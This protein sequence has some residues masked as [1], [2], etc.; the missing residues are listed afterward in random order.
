[1]NN[2]INWLE[3]TN[4][5]QLN[6][7][8]QQWEHLN[9]V[10]NDFQ[11]F[12]SP[13][14]IFSW[15]ETYWKNNWHLSVLTAWHGQQLIAIVPLYYQKETVF[16]L[17]TLYPLGQGE[18]E[19]K[20]VSSEYLDI[21]IHPEYQS[22]TSSYITHWINKRHCD[23]INWKALNENST[24]FKIL[25]STTQNI[26]INEA[27]RYLV[28]TKNWA[29][30]Q[31][32]KNMRSRYR[33]GINQLTKVDAKIDWVKKENIEEYWQIMKNFHQ[34]RWLGKD[35]TGAFGSDEFNT[36]HN[37][38]RHKTPENI[39]MSAIWINN[40]P[41]AIHY[42]F[43]DSSTLYFYQSGW[44]EN[45]YAQLSPSLILHLW[46]IEHNTKLFYDFMMGKVEGSYKAKFS[47]LSHKMY[48]I[49]I[50]VNP[51][52]LIFYKVLK[53]IKSIISLFSMRRTV[54]K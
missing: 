21:L 35:K 49:V 52:K 18:A 11:I 38:L 9:Q 45:D 30:S 54:L 5:E 36:F 44:N 39:A 2:K 29:I 40:T 15:L 17:K 31:L 37:K 42:Y 13:H 16:S 14:W 43:K 1:M 51:K 25:T 50:N 33:R 46:S 3:I 4:I 10:Q 20:E 41:V 32:S 23:Q 26:S 48:N 47:S 12:N 22:A 19:A 34:S 6:T 7:I 53:K 24:A 27:S 28:N 8:K